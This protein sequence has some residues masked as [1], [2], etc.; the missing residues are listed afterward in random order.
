M[1][2]GERKALVYD[3]Y[4]FVFGERGLD[5]PQKVGILVIYQ[6][7]VQVYNGIFDVYVLHTTGQQFCLPLL[8][9]KGKQTIFSEGGQGEGS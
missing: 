6:L 1:V 9:E 7:P 5:A 8:L 3:L 4:Y 2:R